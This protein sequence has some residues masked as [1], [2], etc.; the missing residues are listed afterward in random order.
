MEEQRLS[1]AGLSGQCPERLPDETTKAREKKKQSG[2]QP[3]FLWWVKFQFERRFSSACL[4]REGV[5]HYEGQLRTKMQLMTATE[6]IWLDLVNWAPERANPSSRSKEAH[7]SPGR[8]SASASLPAVLIAYNSW[9][10]VIKSR[11]NLREERQGPG[12]G[13]N[14]LTLEKVIL[15]SALKGLEE[16]VPYWLLVRILSFHCRGLGLIPVRG[17]KISQAL[18]HSPLPHKKS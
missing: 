9:G 12:L 16:G 2:K 18:Q 6:R 8:R 14:I 4:N 7:G 10:P 1:A 15:G 11:W 13:N 5:V 3:G 17:T